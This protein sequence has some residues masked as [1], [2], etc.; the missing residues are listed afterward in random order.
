MNGIKKNK[1]FSILL[2]MFFLLVGFK[3][4]RKTILFLEFK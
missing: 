3:F 1:D 2:Q 4:C